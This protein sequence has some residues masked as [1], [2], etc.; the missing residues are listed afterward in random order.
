MTTTSAEPAAASAIPKPNQPDEAQKSNA[1]DQDQNQK[2]SQ[3]KVHIPKPKYRLHA[4]DLRHPESASFSTY[5]PDV[6]TTLDTALSNIVKYL[7]TSPETGSPVDVKSAPK[8]KRPHF[9]PFIPP[10]RSVTLFL[11]DFGGVA[12]T[13]GTELDDAHKEI[14][15]SLPYITHCKNS[16][17][18]ADPV[19]E[20]AGVLTHELVHCYQHTSPPDSAKGGKDT[21]GPPGGLIEGIA[22]FV[23]LKAGLSPPHWTRPTSSSQREKKWDA[24]YQHTAYFLAWIEDVWAGE[25]AVGMLNDRLFRVGYVGEGAEDEA[26]GHEGGFWKSLFGAGVAELWDEYGQWLDDGE[27]A[28]GN[29]EEEIVNPV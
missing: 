29:W 23:R 4:E 10:T 25:G 1:N 16:A 21:P 13:T 5:I 11:R 18:K 8:C 14:H 2:I 12:Y 15:L 28:K 20:L 17:A 3:K 27:K 7:Y 26:N 22:D 6:A 24:G 19:H 9:V